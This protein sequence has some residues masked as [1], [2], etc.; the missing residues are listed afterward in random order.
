VSTASA[1]TPAKS[2]DGRSRWLTRRALLAHLAIV[3]WVPGCA[4]AAWWQ[5]TVALAGNDL[6]YLYS[7]EWPCFAAFAVVAW[8]NLIHDDP[9]SVGSRALRKLSAA[10]PERSERPV[11]LLHNDAPDDEELRAYNAY[12][13]S[14]SAR[15]A[16]K[17]WKR[18]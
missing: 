14:L 11:E 8:W 10:K 16:P 15:G 7:V 5:V 6:A 9:A 12:L 4:I 1:A 3:I 13:A 2:A 18:R 17:T